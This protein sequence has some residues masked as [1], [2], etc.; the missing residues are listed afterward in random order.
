MRSRAPAVAAALRDA[1]RVALTREKATRVALLVDD[2]DECDSLSHE[3]LRSLVTDP[4]APLTV[5]FSSHVPLKASEVV[6]LHGLTLPEA[7]AF[8]AKNAPSHDDLDETVRR[9]LPLYLEQIERFGARSPQEEGLPTRLADAVSQRFDGLDVGA[10]HLLQAI[11]VFGGRAGLEELREVLDDNALRAGDELTKKGFAYFQGG[12]LEIC[13]PF[14]ARLV[15]AFIPAEARKD[16]HR[17]VQGIMQSRDTPLE[18]IA[19]HAYRS[20]EPMRTL[21]TLERM[22]DAARARGDHATAVLAFR[23]SLELARREMLESGDSVMDTAIVTFSRKLAWALALAGDV[24]RA[25]GV[26]REVLELTGRSSLARAR[27]YVV[28]GRISRLRDKHRDAMRFFGQALELA[29]GED[30]PTELELQL[31]MGEMR[32][33]DDDPAGAANAFRRALELAKEGTPDQIRAQFQLAEAVL[34]IGDTA[35]TQKETERAMGLATGAGAHDLLAHAHGL[36][37]LLAQRQGYPEHAQERFENAAAFAA[38]AGDVPAM[39]RWRDQL[40]SH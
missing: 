38:A 10:R 39:E 36:I 3:V 31:A 5:V 1:V 18:V 20:G 24:A 22:G 33:A 14:I 11:S 17:Q 26:V 37:G 6:E 23:R 15:E 32:L 34:R 2:L 8:L 19:E 27:M 13:H 40:Q 12:G 30:G 21:M 7:E 4:A 16:L 9:Y 28:L 29:A 25:D 35:Q